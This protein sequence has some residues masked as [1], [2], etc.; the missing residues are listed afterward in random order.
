MGYIQ[1]SLNIENKKSINN[2][3]LQYNMWSIK[4]IFFAYFFFVTIVFILL[5]IQETLQEEDNEEG[6][7]TKIALTFHF[8]FVYYLNLMFLIRFC[9][10][11]GNGE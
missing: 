11:V 2:I 6:I 1:Y 4:K 7:K 10:Y 8:R 3:F 5:V 9:L